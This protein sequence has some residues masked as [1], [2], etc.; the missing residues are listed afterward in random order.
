MTATWVTLHGLANE[1]EGKAREEAEGVVAGS[2]DEEGRAASTR[3]YD[4]ETLNNLQIAREAI[5]PV[6]FTRED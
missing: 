3:A 2:T 5:R 1:A 6:V 4:S